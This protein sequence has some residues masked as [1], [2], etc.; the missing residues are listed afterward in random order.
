MNY[1]AKTVP[2]IHIYQMSQNRG[3]CVRELSIGVLQQIGARLEKGGQDALDAQH[4]LI[5]ESV[6]SPD[7]EPVFAS[8]AELLES[9][10][11]RDYVE[12]VK[13]VS[14]AHKPADDAEQAVAEL[15]N[16][17]APTV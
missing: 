2:K 9:C 15:G 3:V 8:A 13:I 6:V 12:L 5:V 7:G 16:G 10:P 14:E 17:S 11:A 1:F 4:Q